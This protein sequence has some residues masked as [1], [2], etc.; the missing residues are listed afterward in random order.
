MEQQIVDHYHVLEERT[1]PRLDEV[2]A[3]L[4][5]HIT[6]ARDQFIN[7]Q[8]IDERR[9]EKLRDEE[10][11]LLQAHYAN[12]IS[13]ELLAEEQR[14]IA[15]QL[16]TAERLAATSEETFTKMEKALGAAIDL[17]RD[18]GATYRRASRNVRKHMNGALL[19]TVFLGVEG[20]T[21][22]VLSSP[23]GLL[24]DPG[25][26]QTLTK[27]R[28]LPVAT[29]LSG[30]EEPLSDEEIHALAQRLAPYERP[31]IA[32]NTK[33]T[34][35]SSWRCRRRCSNNFT[36]AERGGFE[37]PEPVRAQRFS[38]P[39]Q[40]S[41]LPSLRRRG[42]RQTG[43]TDAR[44]QALPADFAGSSPPHIGGKPSY[45]P[46]SKWSILK[47][48]S[49]NPEQ[50]DLHSSG[51]VAQV[52]IA[53]VVALG[54]AATGIYLLPIDG[55]PRAFLALSFAM[56][57]T[58]SITVSKTVRDLHESSRFVK[59]IDEARV[60]KLLTEHPVDV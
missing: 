15:G 10:R 17:A 51:F 1:A 57:T 56:V 53:F 47:P 54:S 8:E 25:L 22:T 32:P 52:W 9:V 13:L 20:V 14:R 44:F 37:P 28:S 35:A 2:E 26:A 29:Q 46:A 34:A 12:A 45:R 50:Q 33:N 38:R 7:E 11:K 36:L 5:K 6:H 30:R 16:H 60:T 18:C 48:M 58:T 31:R 41:T 42:Y 24:F 39:T 49:I 4:T 19:D 21:E 55:W 59:K 43:V 27:E 23:F 40:S 3:A